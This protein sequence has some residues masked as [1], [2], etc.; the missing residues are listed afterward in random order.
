M[1]I[2]FLVMKFRFVLHQKHSFSTEK[3]R[4][5]VAARRRSNYFAPII[6]MKICNFLFSNFLH[7]FVLIQGKTIVQLIPKTLVSIFISYF[8]RVISFRIFHSIYTFLHFVPPP[9]VFHRHTF[10]RFLSIWVIGFL[11]QCLF[12]FGECFSFCV[13]WFLFSS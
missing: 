10:I 12:F 5:T 11:N 3:F 9:H 8:L 13:W 6:V 2:L 4:E 1:N 7:H